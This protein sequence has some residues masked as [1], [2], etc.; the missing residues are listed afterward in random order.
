[1]SDPNTIPSLMSD[2]SVKG[3]TQSYLVMCALLAII[4]RVVHCMIKA[5]PTGRGEHG[6]APAEWPFIKR[7]GFAFWGFD[8]NILTDFWL[9]AIIGFAEISF[10][11]VLIFTNNLSAIGGW[12]AI[13]TAGGWNLW[14][15]Q[16]IA[17]NRF[18][19]TNLVNLAIAYFL[20]VQWIQ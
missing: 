5:L 10:Y 7:F 20:T 12:L 11:P 18:L 17:F 19:V 2:W 6:E 4:V 3:S 13:K 15:E 14:H 1:M 9:G 8:R 16:P